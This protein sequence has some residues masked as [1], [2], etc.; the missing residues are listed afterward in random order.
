MIVR[1]KEANAGLTN[2]DQVLTSTSILKP[3]APRNS[4]YYHKFD[5]VWDKQHTLVPTG[6]DG[7]IGLSGP[8]CMGTWRI[9]INRTV[10]YI[11]A[12]IGAADF[13]Y[14]ATTFINAA[15]KGTSWSNCANMLKDDLHFIAMTTDDGCCSFVV[16]WKL[17]FTDN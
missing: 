4:D 13:T 15:N 14:N 16:Q 3:G 9:P 1:N 10:E 6:A 7:A 17:L 2:I 11:G 8:M 5:I 12:T